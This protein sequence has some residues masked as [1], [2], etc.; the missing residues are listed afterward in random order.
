MF[1]RHLRMFY[2]LSC[3]VALAPAGAAVPDDPA[4][5]AG[6]Y[7][8]DKADATYPNIS[9][10]KA[11]TALLVTGR[12]NRTNAQFS[13]ARTKGAEVLAYI[14][15]VDILDT[16]AQCAAEFFT[17]AQLWP[18]YKI[19]KDGHPVYRTNWQDSKIGDLHVGSSWS[20]AVVAYVENLM[21]G[22]QVDGVF[23]DVVGA[24]LWGISDW[25]NWPQAEKDE[26]TAGNV[27]LVRRINDSRKRINP[28]FIVINNGYWN[29]TGGI[30][31]DNVVYP[32]E[33]YVD[34]IVIEKHPPDAS[35]APYARRPYGNPGAGLEHR[36]MLVI[37]DNPTDAAAWT[38]ATG[39]THVALQ[40]EPEGYKSPAPPVIA[41]TP[42][43]DRPHWFGR[44][45]FGPTPS[46][47]MGADVKRGSKFALAQNGTL[48]SLWAYVD[49]AGGASGVQEM[50]LVLYR[51]NNG[52]PG[53]KVTESNSKW[54]QAGAPAGW[55][56]FIVPHVALTAGN[57]WI[58]LFT[59]ADANVVRNYLDN[60][61]SNWYG[62]SDTF[63]GG[64][65]NPFGSG[66]TRP[67]ELSVF[68]TYSVP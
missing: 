41:P 19:D 1:A 53:A 47:A 32:G 61:K 64:A 60:T 49:G 62:N 39:V 51:D 55:R 44:V 58:T 12:C 36:R 4:N 31:D 22:G 48:G 67:S 11:P 8:Y 27:D 3:L 42:I 52:V 13:D 15:P 68:A 17:G 38:N 66:S 33:T 37:T 20:D 50:R 10:Y 18:P 5:P 57:Y 63:V 25:P 2:A 43:T 45:N 59:G 7:F 46:V 65:S 24:R 21:R 16:P 6:L 40:P 26:W 23:L 14:D 28:Y 29:P 9:S 56:E 30:P 34:G 54:F 35:H